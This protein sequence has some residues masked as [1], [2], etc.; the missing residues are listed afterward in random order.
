MQQINLIAAN[1]NIIKQKFSSFFEL[2][3]LMKS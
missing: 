1:F 2:K 3:D